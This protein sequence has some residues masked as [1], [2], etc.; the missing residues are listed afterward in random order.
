MPADI[1]SNYYIM[2][3]YGGWSPC[4]EGNNTYGLRPFPGSVLPNCVGYTTGRFNEL[5]QLGACT[6]FGNTNADNFLTLGISQ[7]LSYGDDP[8]VGGV[9]VWS[10]SGTG[11]CAVIEQVID[12][13]TVVTS[14]SGWNYTTAPV[15]TTH[16]RVRSGGAWQ[17]PGGTYQG[18][19]YPPFDISGAT[20]AMVSAAWIRRKRKKHGH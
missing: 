9:I 20:G 14:E 17:Y 10:T 3:S 16:T 5:L 4:I 11:H 13:D 12:N 15:V 19:V 1:N 7:G 18:I 2:T 8:V 6:Y